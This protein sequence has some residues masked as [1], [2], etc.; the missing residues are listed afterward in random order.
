MPPETPPPLTEAE[1]EAKTKLREKQSRHEELKE[2]NFEVGIM[3]ASKPIVQ[4]F[5]NPFVG[6]ITNRSA[7][8]ASYSV[9][10]FRSLL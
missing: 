7:V 4:A 2:E 5:T 6:N 3:F 1:Q 8:F 10:P 9:I